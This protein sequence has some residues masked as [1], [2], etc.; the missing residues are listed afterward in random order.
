MSRYSRATIRR[1]DLT[2][3]DFA[4]VC[5]RMS[6]ELLV[7]DT[8]VCLLLVRQRRNAALIVWSG[9][10]AN[11]QSRTIAL[12]VCNRNN[13]CI[14]WQLL[15]V[16]TKTMTMGVWV[17][18]ETGLEDRICRRLDTWDKMRGRERC[19]LDFREVVLR[20]FVQD[21]LANRA[22]REVFV[23][24]HLRQVE[25]VVPEALCLLWRHRLNIDRPAW[26]FTSFDVLEEC[27]DTVVRVRAGKLASLLVRERLEA[28]I[29][30]HMDLDV[31][32]FALLV[33]P[34]ECVAGVAVFT[35]IS[36]RSSA[37]GEQDHH[38]MDRLWV[39]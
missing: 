14:Y 24:P 16:C 18:E 3:C 5:L 37:V 23:R 2:L 9:T 27:L 30:A 13:R 17:R 29:S 38:L 1:N 10:L 25:N 4:Q 28:T 35:V 7:L 22:E 12:E 32:E 33:D 8:S 36:I 21:Q 31:V 15:V 34:L 26:E 6:Q 11:I 19:L 20:V 39:L